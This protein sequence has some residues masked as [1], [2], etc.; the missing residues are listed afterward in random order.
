MTAQN[1]TVECVA[2][3]CPMITVELHFTSPAHKAHK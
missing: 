2:V 1:V 3:V